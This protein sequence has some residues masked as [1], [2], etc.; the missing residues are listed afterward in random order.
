M[1]KVFL[2]RHGQDEDNHEGL[3]NGH[4]DR[5][6]TA[7]GVQQAHSAID[8]LRGLGVGIDA[9]L[10]SPLLR[11]KT[12]AAI[13]SEGMGIPSPVVLPELIERNFGV[14]TGKP[15]DDIPRYTADVLQ[16]DKV[17][18]FLTA[19]GAEGFDE[20]M[21]R[22][23]RVVGHVD[24]QYDGKTVLLV[25]HGDIGK[26]IAAVRRGQDWK[27]GLLAPYFANTEVLELP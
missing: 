18:Y 8:R 21:D 6:L 26:M 24:N 19:E 22:A 13:I 9:V 15:I 2:C 25:C 4:R 23:R 10:C 16:T 7:V 14:L 1:A 20:L 12:T 3:L 27:S 5:P 11:A 17:L